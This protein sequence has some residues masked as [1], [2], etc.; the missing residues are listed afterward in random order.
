MLRKIWYVA[1]KD[2]LQL[3]KDRIGLIWLIARVCEK[4]V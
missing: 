3:T 1:A 2:L 4:S